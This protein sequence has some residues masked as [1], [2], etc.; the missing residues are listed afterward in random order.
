M[1]HQIWKEVEIDNLIFDKTLEIIGKDTKNL[2]QYWYKVYSYYKPSRGH[3]KFL[4]LQIGELGIYSPIS[5]RSLSSK[6]A[7]MGFEWV[8]IYDIPFLF[9]EIMNIQLKEET[10]L[11]TN[12]EL[13]F[14]GRITDSFVIKP[15]SAS[16]ELK[17]EHVFQVGLSSDYRYSRGCWYGGPKPDEHL[18]LNPDDYIVIVQP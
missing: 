5:W 16:L 2:L 1:Q 3:V 15:G 4:R 6:I 14:E 17:T 9:A 7:K 10:H 18:W 8:N 13:T 12:T 11:I